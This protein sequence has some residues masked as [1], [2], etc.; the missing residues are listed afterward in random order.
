MRADGKSV[1]VPV[2][3]T[4]WDFT[5]PP[6]PALVTAFGSPAQRLRD[7]YRQRAKAA[8]ESEPSDWAAVETQCAQLLSDHRFN[9]VP[10]AETLRPVAQ[11]GSFQIPSAQVRVLRE[12][13]DRYH[14]NALEVP[15]PSRV[16]KDPESE[17]DKLHAW[18]AAF[19][20]M[21]KE[22]DRPRIVLY[23]YLKDEPNTREDYEYVQKWGR[24]IREAKSVVQVMVVEQTWTEPGKGGADSA[25]GDL[26]GAVDIWCPLFSLHRQD[27]R[28]PAAGSG[29]DRLGLHRTV[30]GAA[31]TVVAH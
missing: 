7:Y 15:H 30:P 24:A 8:R 21:A 29:R 31:H 10:P 12:F 22:L 25:W 11:D 28:R 6:T 9:A 16:I 1:E 13:V 20:R 5:L 19:D 3:L 26:Y 4:V 14:V 18:L 23:V 17:R 2:T 27:Q